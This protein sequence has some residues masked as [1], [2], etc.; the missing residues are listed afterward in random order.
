MASKFLRLRLL[1]FIGTD[2]T[3]CRQHLGCWGDDTEGRRAIS[4]GNRLPEYK[5]D[6]RNNKKDLI[7]DCHI[8]THTQGWTLFATENQVEC[9]TSADAESTYQMYGMR[10]NC[11]EGKGGFSAFDVYKMVVCINPGMFSV[12]YRSLHS[13]GKT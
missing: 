1:I 6:Y 8:Y 7:E 11:T 3:V 9:F 10:D 12:H 4:G 5:D 13:S 2:A